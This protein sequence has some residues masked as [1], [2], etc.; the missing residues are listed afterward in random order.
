MSLPTARPV[1][2][3]MTVSLKQESKEVEGDTLQAIVL[4][5]WK[6]EFGLAG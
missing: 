2:I 5:M 6:T 1:W 4:L 3:K